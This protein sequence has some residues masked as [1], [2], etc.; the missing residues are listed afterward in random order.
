MIIRDSDGNRLTKDIR[1][2]ADIRGDIDRGIIW[3]VTVWHGGLNG[4]V[5]GTLTN[6]SPHVRRFY[7]RT[8]AQA[9]GADI[10]DQVGQRGRVA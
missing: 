8:R 5:T 6:G 3:G 1:P 7:Y 9:R 10:T 4:F 2:E